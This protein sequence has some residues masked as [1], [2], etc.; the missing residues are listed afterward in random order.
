[1]QIFQVI[2]CQWVKPPSIA[3]SV[4]SWFPR[5]DLMRRHKARAFP[6]PGPNRPRTEP[7]STSATFRPPPPDRNLPSN[8]FAFLYQTLFSRFFRAK[9]ISLGHPNTRTWTSASPR[10]A[11][12]SRSAEAL[13]VQKHSTPAP[14]QADPNRFGDVQGSEVKTTHQLLVTSASLLVTSALLVVTRSY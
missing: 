12:A 9:D 14:F 11:S 13:L 1:M 3:T 4:A 6:A 2:F 7:C 5:G 8:H 10:P